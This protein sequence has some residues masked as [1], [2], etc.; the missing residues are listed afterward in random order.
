LAESFKH[1]NMQYRF[2]K[3]GWTVPETDVHVHVVISDS[4]G[5]EGS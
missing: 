4:S 1:E 5:F 3:H 2:L